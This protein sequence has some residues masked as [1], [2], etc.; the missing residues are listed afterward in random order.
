MN[1]SLHIFITHYTPLTERKT[2]IL[3]ELKEKIGNIKIK[4]LAS[5]KEE[6]KD[7]YTLDNYD[8]NKVTHYVYFV[9]KYDREH[10]TPEIQKQFFLNNHNKDHNIRLEFYGRKNYQ[11]EK[12][13]YDNFK[14]K[15]NHS[16]QHRGALSSSQKSLCLKHYECYRLI[17][18]YNLKYALIIEDDCFF[19]DNFMSKLSIYMNEFPEDWSVYFPNGSDNAGIRTK[20]GYNGRFSDEKNTIIKKSPNGIFAISYMVTLNA[21]KRMKKYI[22]ENKIWIP[23]DHEHNWI[24]YTLDFKVIWNKDAGKNITIWNHTNFKSSIKS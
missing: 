9:K 20:G 8:E 2:Y 15:Y 23:I 5:E 4:E 18:E 6:E 10:L 12:I 14:S 16:L 17:E 22:D 21:A 7:F 1:D 19:K 13:T 11:T 3:K 24:F